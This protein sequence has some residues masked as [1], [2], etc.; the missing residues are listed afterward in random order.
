MGWGTV[1]GQNGRRII[2]R[3][4]KMINYNNS[5][6]NKVHIS[7][8]MNYQEEWE[9]S[10]KRNGGIRST[11]LHHFILDEAVNIVRSFLF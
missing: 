8:A 3:L 9:G 6:N 2:T 1:E 11:F 4:R 5:S 10:C 7:K